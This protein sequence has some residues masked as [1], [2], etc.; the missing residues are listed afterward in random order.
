[1]HIVLILFFGIRMSIYMSIY[2]FIYIPI[3]LS[4]YLSIYVR[5][6]MC[7]C[8]SYLCMHVMYCNVV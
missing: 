2:I 1:M 8:V 6:Y 4:M 3:Y 7:V 5:T